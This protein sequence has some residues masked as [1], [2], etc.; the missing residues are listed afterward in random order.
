MGTYPL[1]TRE[2]ALKSVLSLI[3]TRNIFLDF[4]SDPDKCQLYTNCNTPEKRTILVKKTRA[5]LGVLEAIK[6]LLEDHEA[7]VTNHFQFEEFTIISGEYRRKYK[8][9]LNYTGVCL[10]EEGETTVWMPYC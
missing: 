1:T 5:V 7:E 6:K 2:R 10:T 3:A 8:A 9:I 4:V